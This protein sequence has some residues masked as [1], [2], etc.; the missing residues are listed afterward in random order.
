MIVF[1]ESPYAG[2]HVSARIRLVIVFGSFGLLALFQNYLLNHEYVSLEAMRRWTDVMMIWDARDVA[3]STLVL[4]FPPVPYGL[5]LALHA[6]PPL[7]GPSAS[8]ALDNIAVAGVVGSFAGSVYRRTQSATWSVVMAALVLLNPLMLWIATSGEGHGVLLGAYYLLSAAIL[9]LKLNPDVRA[10]IT[11]SAALAFLA[12][13]DIRFVFIVMALVPLI[14]FL[15]DPGTIERS[16]LSYYAVVLFAPVVVLLTHAYLNW[17]FLD[18]ALAFVSPVDAPF[19]GV[20]ATAPLYPW[21]RDSGG[22]LFSPMI[23]GVGFAAL[24]APLALFVLPPL[25]RAR[26]LAFVALAISTSVPVLAL[27][28][29][30]AFSYSPHPAPFIGLVLAPTIQSAVLVLE[31]WGRRVVVALLLAFGTL[32]G[33]MLVTWKPT[34]SMIRWR[35]ALAGP[36]PLASVMELDLGHWLHDHADETLVDDRSAYVAIVARESAHNLFLPPSD[37]FKMAVIGGRVTAAQIVIPLPGTLAA[38]SDRLAHAFPTLYE[39]GRAGYRL[40]YDGPGWRVYRSTG[41]RAG[42]H[43]RF[44]TGAE[45]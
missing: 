21:L 33:W 42:A 35:T 39:H 25:A 22:S 6:I 34:A 9:R 43:G 40:A 4:I 18:D 14:A 11:L 44:A 19:R 15:G 10:Q 12:L 36:A 45:H 30:T 20:A 2:D 23:A 24:C 1:G 13:C 29:S 16:P 38:V 32:G 5:L 41:A 27:G 37:E 31:R 17:V 8:Y 28:L 3:R 7:G 26:R